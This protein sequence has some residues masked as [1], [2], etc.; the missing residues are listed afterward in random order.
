MEHKNEKELRN[1]MDVF[2]GVSKEEHL[3]RDMDCTYP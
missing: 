2:A 3:F 1:R